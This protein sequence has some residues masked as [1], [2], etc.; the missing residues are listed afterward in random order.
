MLDAGWR[1]W[2]LAA[3]PSGNRRGIFFVSATHNHRFYERFIVMK[4][5][6]KLIGIL[7]V[8]GLLTLVAGSVSAQSLK[9]QFDENGNGFSNGTSLQ[10]H[11]PC[12]RS[13]IRS[14]DLD[15]STALSPVTRGDLIL[16]ES[17]GAISDLIR[18]DDNSIGGVAYFFSDPADESPAP[19]ADNPF[20]IPTPNAAYPPSY[21]ARNRH[22][23]ND[24]ATYLA[25]AGFPGCACR[26]EYR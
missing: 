4:T 11:L 25:T 16:T 13:D 3:L 2:R 9:A 12:L 10:L 26:P 7:L 17:T 20:G 19:L 21:C 6:T 22:E 1:T 23:G 5:T 14:L 8:F 24:G 18:F 15:V